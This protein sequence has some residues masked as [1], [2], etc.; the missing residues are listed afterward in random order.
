MVAWTLEGA[1]EWEPANIGVCM[2]AG[3]QDL[4]D[5]Q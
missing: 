3:L 5:I 2:E 4:I 1:G